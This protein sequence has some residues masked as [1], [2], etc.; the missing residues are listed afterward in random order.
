M[1]SNQNP[2]GVQ[3][4]R[5]N[6]QNQPQFAPEKNNTFAI[7]SL[8][9]GVLSLGFLLFSAIPG[10][11]YG[12]LALSRVKRD[13]ETYSGRGMAITGLIISYLFI[14]LSLLIIGFYL[15]LFLYVD[16]FA[17]DFNR[18]FSRGFIGY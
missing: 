13:P 9:L 16:G 8:V 10:V 1:A 14:L 12:H 7:V 18:G 6:Q 3:P 4:N 5:L 2:Y 17:E 11:I 15:Y